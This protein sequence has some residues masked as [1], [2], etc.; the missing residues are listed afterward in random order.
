MS[1]LKCQLIPAGV[2]LALLCGWAAM[3]MRGVGTTSAEPQP[4]VRQRGDVGGGPQATSAP[5]QPVPFDGKRAL[6]HIRDLCKLGPRISGSEGMR[7][8]QDLLKEHFEKL[9]GKVEFQ[10]F[11][12][13]QTSRPNPVAMANF[14]AS[15]HPDRDRR[16]ILCTHYD[17]RPRADQEENPRKW[18]EPFLSANDGTS[19]VAWLMELARHVKQIPAAVG[20]DFVLFD[21]EE[22]VFDG[23]QGQDRYFFGSDH[24]ADEYKRAPPRHRYVGAVLLDL[25]AHKN[26]KF[27]IERNSWDRAA[28]L[29]REVWRTAA[30]VKVDAFLSHFAGPYLDDHLALNRV[31]IPAV[32]II[33]FDYPHWHKLSDLPEN[34][35]AETMEQVA[36]VLTAWMQRVR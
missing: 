1:R 4:P 22:Y 3:E 8:Q 9:G 19:G 25:F 21:G 10:R 13:R 36:K 7:K 12:A 15:W 6:D 34:C 24:F 2:A 33:D 29:V 5:I 27:P 18:D 17:T 31:S 35:S 11:T 30:E 28:P 23:P 16:V 26:A 32:D 14:I 20:I